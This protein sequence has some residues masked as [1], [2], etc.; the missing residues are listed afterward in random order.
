MYYVIISLSEIMSNREND[1]QNLTGKVLLATPNISDAYVHKSIVFICKHSKEGALG[2]I[3]N[4]IIPQLPFV[5]HMKLDDIIGN[6]KIHIGGNT[7]IDNCYILHTNSNLSGNTIPICD[8]IFLTRCDD[9]VRSL[10]FVNNEPERKILCLG[11]YNW[12]PQQ[13][14]NEITSNYWI[15]IPADEALIFGSSYVDKWDKAFLKIGLHSSLFL[16]KSGI[17]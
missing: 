15:P 3:V 16:N 8:D 2:V 6:A 14:E 10:S 5:T 12:D 7:D 1:L 17:A 4:K 11:C 13:L 9:I